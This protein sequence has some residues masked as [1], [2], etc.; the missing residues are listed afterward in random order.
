MM[1]TTSPT[2]L[3]TSAT[4][5]VLGIECV[6]LMAYLGRSAKGDRWRA[7]LWSWVFGLLAL[8][9]L[10]GTIAHGFEMPDSIRAALWKPIYLSLGILVA[11]FLVGAVYDWRGRVAAGRLV[12]WGI[13][14]GAALFGLTEFFEGAFI[15]FVVYEAT[16]MVSVL[17]IYSLLAATHRLK[18]A[19]VISLAILLNLVAAGVQATDVS[20]RIVFPFD[21]NG[22]FHFVQMVALGTLGVGLRLGMRL[23]AR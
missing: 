21:H 14:A 3:T 12:P 19:G 15:V 11:L 6:M 23:D 17:A 9:A 13:G 10:L 8:S 22:V 7:G 20:V 1:I 4:D 5:A 18:G 2:E 16:V